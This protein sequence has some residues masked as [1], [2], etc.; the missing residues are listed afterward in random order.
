MNIGETLKYLR[1]NKNYTKKA[2]AEGIVSVSFYSQV[3][4]GKSSITI[5][6]FLNC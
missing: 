1:E 4:S 6:L 2:L 3:E 5:E